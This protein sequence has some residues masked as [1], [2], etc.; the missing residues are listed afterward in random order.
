MFVAP[1]EPPLRLGLLFFS[2]V[3]EEIIR[4]LVARFASARMPWVVVERAPVHAL[5]MA[6]GPRRTDGDDAI[7]RLA[8]EAERSTRR[9]YGDALPPMSLRKPLRPLEVRLVLEMA[10]ASL[11]PEHVEAVMPHT[12]PV[13]RTS[14]PGPQFRPSSLR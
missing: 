4:R 9:R 5:F 6:R 13:P 10:A 11:L 14:F 1:I 7:L 2:R 8:C 12:R 3:D